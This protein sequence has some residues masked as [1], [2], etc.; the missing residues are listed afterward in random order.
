MNQNNHVQY[1]DNNIFAK[2]LKGEIPYHKVFEDD[3]TLAF[4]D[5]MPQAKGH[6]LVIPKQNAIDLADLEPEYAAAVLMT[7]KKVMQAQRQVFERE[8]IIQ[9]Q[10]NGSQAGQTVFHYHVHLIP[11]SIHELGRHAVTQADQGELA[12]L[13]QQLA[14]VIAG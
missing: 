4:M 14:A 1:D 11:S 13:A 7:A 9:M 2:M 10:L 8:G 3:K 6:V 12:D 5:I